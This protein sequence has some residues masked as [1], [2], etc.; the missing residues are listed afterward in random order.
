MAQEITSLLHPFSTFGISKAPLLIQPSVNNVSFATKKE[1]VPTGFLE[2][3]IHIEDKL[4]G[5]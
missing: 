3:A 2:K 4:S 5:V 1:Y